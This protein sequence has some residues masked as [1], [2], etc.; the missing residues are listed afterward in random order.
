M[1]NMANVKISNLTSSWT[2]PTKDYTGLGLSINATSFDPSSKVFRLKVNGN[3]IFSVDASGT[4]SAPTIAIANAVVDIASPFDKANAAF[5]VANS[6]YTTT[7]AAY[8]TTNAAYTTSN[9]AFFHSNIT[10][11]AVNSVFGVA[12]AAFASAN[13]VAPQVAPAYNTANAAFD[14]ANSAYALQNNDYTMSNAAYTVA[15]AA[16][17]VANAAF[18]FANNVTAPSFNTANAAFTSSNTK[19]SSVS[20]TSGRITSSGGTT[21]TIDLATAGGGAA[22]Y[23]SGISAIT[24][25]AYGRVTGV[26]G[27][28]NYAPLSGATFSG[29]VR[30]YRSYSTG[31]GVYYFSQS[32]DYYLYWDG[33]AFQFNGGYLQATGSMRSPIFYDS[34]NTGFY[35]DPA[36]TSNLSAATVAGHTYGSYNSQSAQLTV[37]G[38]TASG[39][40]IRASNGTFGVQ[41]YGDGTDYG[42]L[43]SP[44]GN[45]DFDK[46]IGGALYLNG[47]NSYYLQPESTSSFWRVTCAQDSRAPIFYDTNNTAY[48]VDPASTSVLYKAD[49]INWRASLDRAWGGFPSITVYNTTDQGGQGEFRI[50]GYP[51]SNGGDFS[52]NLRVDGSYYGYVS[53]L[54]AMYDSNNTGYYC[55]PTGRSKFSSFD[56]DTTCN[57]F[58]GFGSGDGSPG[59]AIENQGTFTRLAYHRFT[60]WDWESGGDILSLSDGYPQATN[61]M[62]APIFYDSNDTGFYCDPNNTTRINNLTVVGTG[63]KTLIQTLTASNSPSLGT[64][65]CFS[66]AYRY[67][68]I[69]FENI[70]P[71]TTNQYGA[72]RVYSGGAYQSANY[73]YGQMIA[74]N[75]TWSASA[76]FGVFTW[77]SNGTSNNTTYAGVSGFFKVFNPTNTSYHKGFVGS[78]TYHHPGNGVDLT[79]T[80]SFRWQGGTG[81]ITGFQI[82]FSS[83]NI[84]FGTIKIY[85][86][87]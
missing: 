46:I 63:G 52:I 82:Y 67:Y 15:N 48:Y 45:W 80:S 23:S 76:G 18:T 8:T 37:S 9:A 57:F 26:T 14:V 65:D 32:G 21:P 62:R 33:S 16:Y 25:D 40:L 31:T 35:V 78:T 54:E 85:G 1:T 79:T 20:G 30:T 66:S 24:V 11:N 64:T 34:N 5:L 44:W 77:V 72:I 6:S 4:V 41:L 7:N 36:S 29:D 19:V 13:N 68:E 87:N 28:A 59:F 58:G 17:T 42:F 83:G 39:L 3:T 22:S 2:D 75:Y 61:S 50:H 81:A 70:T 74:S 12:N 60:F 49:I 47:S 38:T 86:W 53:Y 55:D 84:A 69:V 71:A 51:G 43:A 10:Y 56:V 27:S 73:A